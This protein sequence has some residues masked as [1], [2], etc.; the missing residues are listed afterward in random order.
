MRSP[1][2]YV[3][4]ALTSVHCSDGEVTPSDAR[5]TDAT[6]RQDIYASDSPVDSLA[7]RDADAPD[8]AES[9]DAVIPRDVTLPMDRV[10]PPA[11]CDPR[12]AL[13]PSAPGDDAG[14]EVRYTD[15]TGYTF[16]G[17]AFAGPRMPTYRF[18]EVVPGS[19]FTWR[20]AVDPTVSGRYTVTFTAD[21]GA[22]PMGTCTF[23]VAARGGVRDAG[24]ADVMSPPGDV[25]VPPLPGP[26]RFGMGLVGPGNTSQ[27]DQVANLTGPGGYVKLIF[28]GVRP[29]MTAPNPEWANAVRDAYARELIPVVRFAPDWG[30]R[31][32]RNQADSGSNNRRYTGLAAS[33][34]AILRGLP[35]RRGWPLYV[36]VHN[37][38]NL[39]YE[40]QCDPGSI[41]GGWI[42]QDQIAGEYAALVRDVASAVRAVGNSDLRVINGGLAP[43]GIR[44]CMCTGTRDAGPGEWEGGNTSLDFIRA[45]NTQTPNWSTGLDA[46]ASHA[47]PARGRGFGFFAPYSESAIGLRYYNDEL[48]A[49]GRTLPVLLTET[50]WSTQR[51]PSG[52]N[53]R[54][55]I[56]TWTRQAYTDLWLTDANVRAVMP[57]MLQDS[58]WDRFAWVQSSGAPYPVYTTIRALRCSRIAGRCP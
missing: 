38:P 37:E 31:R 3:L 24:A 34:V 14:F 35:L 55:E 27:L 8:A 44:R 54:D 47:Y 29:G 51:D 39:C 21:N 50:G 32:V 12:F 40:W 9:M 6:E 42:T 28:A 43:G 11:S 53:S 56:A 20:F 16:I 25:A 4:L 36:E 23:E 46:F 18:V 48:A 10:T 26:N 1:W 22:R 5:R 45:M 13:M 2:P 52:T 33:Y 57:F 19:R 58:S 30:D 7:P 15:T 17:L 49:L 41:A